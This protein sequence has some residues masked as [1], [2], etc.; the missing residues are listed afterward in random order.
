MGDQKETGNFIWYLLI[1]DE[2]KCVRILFF[3][4]LYIVSVAAPA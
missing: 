4:R 3:M 2:C 1:M